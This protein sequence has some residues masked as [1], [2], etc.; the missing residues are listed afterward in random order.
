QIAL[1]RIGRVHTFAIKLGITASLF[2][3]V[4]L[5]RVPVRREE[6]GITIGDGKVSCRIFH[7][8]YRL[9]IVTELFQRFHDQQGLEGFFSNRAF[10]WQYFHALAWQISGIGCH[11]GD[12]QCQSCEG[13]QARRYSATKYMKYGMHE[14]VLFM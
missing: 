9:Y 11:G 13:D 5:Q 8:L 6:G 4:G 10:E 3:K 2:I 7:F 1:Y 14:S 12:R